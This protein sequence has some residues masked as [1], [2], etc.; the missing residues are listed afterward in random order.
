MRRCRI[1]TPLSNTFL[2][3]ACS[4]AEVKADAAEEEVEEFKKPPLAVAR[5]AQV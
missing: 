3:T 4:S 2:A 1:E 5:Q